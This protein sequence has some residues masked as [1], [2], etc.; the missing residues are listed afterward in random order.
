LVGRSSRG[1]GRGRRN[2]KGN[3]LATAYYLE[4][5]LT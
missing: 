2:E 3:R 1:R 5:M 4:T